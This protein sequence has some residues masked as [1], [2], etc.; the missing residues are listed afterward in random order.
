VIDEIIPEPMGGAHRDARQAVA[1][2]EAAIEKALVTLGG[3][4]GPALLRARRDRFLAM[5]TGL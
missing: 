4:D 1:A 5:G 2:T 3:I